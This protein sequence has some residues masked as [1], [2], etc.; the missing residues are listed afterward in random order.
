M[1]EG[2][3]QTAI[4]NYLMYEQNKGKLMVWRANNT[5][6]YDKKIN[7]HRKLPFGGRKGVPDICTVIAGKFVGFEV[8]RD[9]KNKNGTYKAKLS[10]DQV[11][12]KAM[13]DA[14]GGDYHEVH[15][16]EE[17]IEILKKYY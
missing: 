1:R 7:G 12:F 8:K 4:I 16:V 3:I 14:N 10:K 6:V 9:D 17:V 15:G 13:I 11:E 5:G 2:P